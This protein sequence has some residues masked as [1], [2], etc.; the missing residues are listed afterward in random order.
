MQRQFT[1]ATQTRLGQGRSPMHRPPSKQH[2]WIQGLAL[3][4]LL[5][6]FMGLSACRKPAK[7]PRIAPAHATA[8]S[9]NSSAQVG[10]ASTLEPG[11]HSLGLLRA[12]GSFEHVTELAG[13]QL[14]FY[15]PQ[16]PA[17]MPGSGTPLSLRQRRDSGL[18]NSLLIE[19]R[20]WDPSLRQWQKPG[21]PDDC[22]HNHFLATATVL[23]KG[24]QVL[25]AGGLCDEP[26]EATDERPTPAFTRLVRWDAAQHRWHSAGQLTEGRIFH[27]ATALPDG[28]VMI[29]GGQ[30]DPEGMPSD[31]P[32]PVLS[33][34]ERWQDDQVQAAP[35]LALARAQHSTTA[36]P[37]GGLLVVGGQG[38]QGQALAQVERWD[39]AGKRWQTIAPLRTARYRHSATLLS[40]GRVLVAGGFGPGGQAIAA[41]E[42][43]DPASGQWSGH[44]PLPLPLQGH[45][46]VLLADGGVLVVGRPVH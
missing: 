23:A 40:D 28:S 20:L 46:A 24:E 7:E 42:V 43:F 37:D 4:A 31:A 16:M 2:L 32:P 1:G 33:T 5:P 22:T 39:P 17:L 34:V 11:L 25:F 38:A 3:A 36:L 12:N 21:R 26:R 13:G 35:S 29:V 9:T 27:T 15:G 8:A 30:R 14:L 18:P 10:N 41:V 45:S 6:L 19:P 44:A